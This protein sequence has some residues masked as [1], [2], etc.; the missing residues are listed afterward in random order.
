VRVLLV[1]DDRK[2]ARLVSKGLHEAGF[3]VDV[4]YSGEQGDE[5]AATSDYAAIVL[6]WLLPGRDGIA[7]W[8]GIFGRVASRHRSSC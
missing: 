1:E 6:D 2:A 8:A 3:L 4:A 5:M 7:F